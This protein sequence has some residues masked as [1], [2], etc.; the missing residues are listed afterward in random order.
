MAPR[1]SPFTPVVGPS[2]YRGRRKGKGKGKSKASEKATRVQA[3]SW[4]KAALAEA[5]AAEASA[6]RARARARGQARRR[7]EEVAASEAADWQESYH[8]IAEQRQALRYTGRWHRVKYWQ[9]EALAIEGFEE[10]KPHVVKFAPKQNGTRVERLAVSRVRDLENEEE[11]YARGIPLGRLHDLPIGPGRHMGGMRRVVIT[12]LTW[13]PDEK[14]EI[15]DDPAWINIGWGMTA[16]QASRRA[17]A[18]VHG[19]A[20]ALANFTASRELIFTALE[21]KYWTAKQGSTYI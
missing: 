2:F 8:E 15:A 11:A 6:V 14:Y 17:A 12:V 9:E 10:V 13:V 18:F 7:G 4:L 1:R 20:R 16:K 5:S 3:R 21:I 19:Y